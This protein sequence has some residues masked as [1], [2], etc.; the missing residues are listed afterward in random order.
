MVDETYRPLITEIFTKV[1]NAKDKPK[2][3]D[4][5]PKKEEKAKPDSS[6]SEL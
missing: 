1:N 4:V 5:K 3:D 6:S 2:K